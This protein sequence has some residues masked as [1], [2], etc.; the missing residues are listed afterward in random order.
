MGGVRKFQGIKESL[1]SIFKRK[2]GDKNNAQAAEQKP[3][4]AAAAGAGAATTEATATHE[5]P[6]AET[7][8]TGPAQ[9]TPAISPGTS[10]PEQGQHNDHEAPAPT[11]LPQ[12]PPIETTE[13]AAPAETP[14]AQ[15]TAG[16]VGGTAPVEPTKREFI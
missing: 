12:I 9:S 6:A 8:A 15:P 3:E 5:A 14:A 4:D 2:K 13:S 1:K 16:L 11:P 7:Q 10:I